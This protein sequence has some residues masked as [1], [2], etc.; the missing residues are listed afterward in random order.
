MNIN[1][2]RIFVN[3][4]ERF[5]GLFRLQA[6]T[7]GKAM[8]GGVGA[9]LERPAAPALSLAGHLPA[10]D[11]IRAVAVMLVFLFHAKVPGFSAGFLGVDVFFVLSGFLITGLLLTE[12]ER[13]GS[14]DYPAFLR[15]RTVRLMPAL[16][17]MV[18]VFVGL[19]GIFPVEP[20]KPAFQAALAVLYL[21]DYGVAF[22]DMPDELSHAWS[23]AVEAKFYLIWPAVVLALT[24]RIPAERLWTAFAL[25]ALIATLWRAGNAVFLSGWDIT[26]YRFDTRLS[27]LLAGAALAAALRAGVADRLRGLAP[28]LTVLLF[29][30]LAVTPMQWGDKGLLIWGCAISEAATIGLIVVV[31]GR[32]GIIARGLSVWPLVGLGRLSYGVYLW[33][34]P[35]I[36]GLRPLVDWPGVAVLGFAVSLVLAW[37]SFVTVE[38]AAAAYRARPL[39]RQ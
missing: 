37:L 26:Y 15:R 17:V 13:K 3:F 38:R 36:R 30:A 12:V 8:P 23:L 32:P 2:N 11:G 4:S 22:A 9:A 28:V 24:K 6:M 27:G 34:Y 35:V 29:A 1:N 7:P 10:L 5:P 21:A 14:L 18:A 33:H 20:A 31:V 25:L 19:A 39:T 16:L